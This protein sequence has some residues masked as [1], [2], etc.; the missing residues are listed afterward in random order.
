MLVG[1]LCW[2]E[3]VRLSLQL[4][5]VNL[6]ILAVVVAD[7]LG[8]DKRRWAGVGIGI[9][10][11]IKLTPALFILYLVLIGRRRAAA[12]ASL[13]FAATVLVGFL[14]LP[15]DSNTFWLRGGFDDVARI[16]SDAIANT[17]LRGLFVRL[18]VVGAST[19]IATAVLAVAAL[20]VA[21]LAWRRG[22]AVLGLAI[23]GL[24][25]AAVSPFSW[26]HHWVWVTLVLVHKGYRAYVLGSR[27]S[28]VAVWL[29]WAT[30]AGWVV[31][32]R[33]DTPETGV[34][35]LRGGGL[36]DVV[37]P[38]AYL[39]GFAVVLI[40][41]AWWLL[42]PSSYDTGTTTGGVSYPVTRTQFD[43]AERSGTAACTST[44]SPGNTV[45]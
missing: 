20:V 40:G 42:R 41:T 39:L 22:H 14:F 35:S 4:G 24:T 45:T 3:P 5:Q 38:A 30:Y 7:V 44:V 26:S 34:L 29:L 21:V 11:G 15:R 2:L 36:L 18:D 13:T 19:T 25:T 27:W 8:P 43:G 31:H 37:T 28:M 6:V 12:V 1:L 17:S 9:V 16:T 33:G 32:T 23:V 10:A